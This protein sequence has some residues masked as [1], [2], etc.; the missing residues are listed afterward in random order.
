MSKATVELDFF[1]LQKDASSNR[2]TLR[3]HSPFLFLST[4]LFH[5]Y[6]SLFFFC[7]HFKDQPRPYQISHRLCLHFP[8]SCSPSL[9]QVSS[10]SLF[11]SPLSFISSFD[12][13]SFLSLRPDSSPMTIFY[14]GTVAVFHLPPHKVDYSSPSYHF[15][16]LLLILSRV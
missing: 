16:S 6:S 2:S 12:F 9:H 7:R 5:S 11:F 13:I 8:A 4:L 15:A 10:I 3:G 1:G 14:N